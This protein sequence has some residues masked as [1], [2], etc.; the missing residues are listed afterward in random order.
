[1][2]N[3]YN[4]LSKAVSAFDRNLL[5]SYIFL[6]DKSSKIDHSSSSAF[7][8][9]LNSNGHLGSKKNMSSLD[10]LADSSKEFKLPRIGD[11]ERTKTNNYTGNTTLTHNDKRGDNCFSV[12]FEDTKIMN[13]N[14]STG[15]DKIL[16]E[17]SLFDVP[18]KTKESKKVN[19]KL[20]ANESSKISAKST[21]NSLK[22]ANLPEF[23]NYFPNFK[24]IEK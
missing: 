19:L 13:T 14:V 11:T 1:M 18:S 9:N 20:S 2:F 22:Y 10:K 17:T 7:A 16:E 24:S 3:D 23:R 5:N 12:N 15:W 6:R 4:K 8:T 21:V